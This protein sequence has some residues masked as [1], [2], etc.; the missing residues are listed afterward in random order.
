MSVFKVWEDFESESMNEKD[1]LQF[2][3]GLWKDGVIK[4][5]QMMIDDLD[6]K[7]NNDLGDKKFKKIVRYSL[8]YYQDEER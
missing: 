8:K 1:L 2:A 5:E 3:I 6:N 7:S 4:I